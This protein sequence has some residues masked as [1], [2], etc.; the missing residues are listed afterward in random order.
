MG[1]FLQGYEPLIILLIILLLLGPTKLPALARGLGQALWEFRK[2]ASG[3]LEE[4]PGKE[5]QKTGAEPSSP[6]ADD[7]VLEKIAAKLA[8][9]TRKTE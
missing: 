1:A 9:E 4:P 6:T 7:E 2:A 5:A 8:S 3:E